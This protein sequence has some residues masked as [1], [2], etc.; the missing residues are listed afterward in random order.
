[1]TEKKRGPGRP[2]GSRNK[3]QN[4][5]RRN[6]ESIPRDS[7]KRAGRQA[8]AKSQRTSDRRTTKESQCS[9]MSAADSAVRRSAKALVMIAAGVF[10]VLAIQTDLVGV[11]GNAVGGF[12]KGMFGAGA[13]LIPYI[14]IVWGIMM[15]IGRAGTF[16]P[17]TAILL[18]ILFLM[19]DLI[20]AARFVK[21]MKYG[22]F[23]IEDVFNEGIKLQNGG[24]FG[25][26]AGTQIYRMT[27]MAGLYIIAIAVILICLFLLINTP[28]SRMVEIVKD[29]LPDKKEEKDTQISFLQD[30]EE[31]PFDHEA[32]VK[33]TRAQK[34]AAK[35]AENPPRPERKK[36]KSLKDLEMVDT[37]ASYMPDMSPGDHD[38]WKVAGP[39]SIALDE[40]EAE[41]PSEEEDPLEK[42]P[43]GDNKK[44][45]LKMLKNEYSGGG[46]ESRHSRTSKTSEPGIHIAGEEKEAHDGNDR[47]EFD[48][49]LS[50][51]KV[52]GRDDRK[53]KKDDDDF[54]GFKKTDLSKEGFAAAGSAAVIGGASVATAASKA[55]SSEGEVKVTP[56]KRGSYKL[57]PLD[58]LN[59][60][61]ETGKA[62]GLKQDLTQK[63]AMLEKTLSS[64]NV[65]A[66]VVNVIS[67]PSVT[68]YEIEPA[69]GVKVQSITRLADDIALNMRARSIRIE[70]PIPG[71]AAVGIEIENESRQMVGFREIVG[72]SAFRNHKSK[73][74]FT[75]GR[76]IGGN[77]VVADLAKM[78]HLLI[79]GAT[80]SGKSVCINTI[81]NS[82]LYKA[83]PE[84]VKMVLIDPKM[85][86]L[87][88]YNGIPHL[89]I[90]V[91]TDA[92]KA[93]AALNWAVAEM[94]RRYK[95]FARTGVREIGAYNKLMKDKGERDEILPQ[96]VVIIDELADLMMVA[97]SQVE[98]SICRIAQLARAAGMH[99]VV[100]TQRPSVDVITGLIKANIPSR[101]AF[102]VS[103][104]IDSRTI[105]DMPGAEKLVGNGDMLFKP[106]DLNKPKR[107]QGPFIDDD[108]VERV[109]E[110]VK[111]Q[112]GEADYNDEVIEQIEKSRD[113]E[114]NDEDDALMM[115]AMEAV[116]SAGQASASMLQRRF[117]IGYNRAARIIDMMEARGIV[118]PQ[119][120]SRPRQ[121]LLTE[122]ELE[123]IKE[124]S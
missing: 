123:Q 39:S 23:G 38:P 43:I 13:F 24:V 58:L 112:A 32:D 98:D 124:N 50:D 72:S 35:K 2:K 1:M 102:M 77:P 52:L 84:E 114:G 122:A 18:V 51:S 113:Y 92:S 6:T 8:A 30:E 103:S 67:G 94:T 33:E 4:T 7:I 75:V 26:Y 63:A 97:S 79:A 48:G 86:E 104:Q 25:M 65:D 69:R 108:E 47:D 120:G 107:I 54:L 101:I 41:R 36:R 59:P 90:P 34:R 20:N 96:I 74:S 121:V 85:V 15:F 53:P 109:I 73:L 71:K 5:S 3:K 27:G 14:M 64:F 88:N 42:L 93:A 11:A 57:P 31:P 83:R 46:T 89:L 9:E 12:F 10:L 110:Y 76:D 40:L 19:E 62:P 105:I 100:A 17:R 119:D 118:G 37:Y 61:K 115:D 45:I 111:G 87:G 70:A 44:N 49:F 91:V 28:V 82:I 81:I 56:K 78:P 66:R 80:G 95:C 55:E 60:V 16:R 29:G 117:R 116:V 99:L 68:R 21:S 106:Q 22:I